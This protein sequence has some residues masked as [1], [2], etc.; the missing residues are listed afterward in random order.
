MALKVDLLQDTLPTGA[1][2]DDIS[3]DLGGSTPNAVM[4]VGGRSTV[5]GTAASDAS[6][7]VG[8]A[9][10]TD[11][12][13]N[14]NVATEDD[15]ASTDVR[16]AIRSDRVREIMNA[17]G[18]TSDGNCDLS[19]F[20]ADDVN[21]T[22][23]NTYGSAWLAQYLAFANGNAEAG[24]G[25]VHATQ[26]QATTVTLGWRPGLVII[27]Y[28]NRELASAGQHC[29]LSVGAL[30]D[31]SD[32][33]ACSVMT[34][35][36]AQ[37][38]GEPYSYVSDAYCGVSINE[39]DGAV[40]HA[41][42]GAITAT[43]FTIETKLGTPNDNDYVFGYLALDLDGDL[44]YVGVQDSPTSTGDWTP[45][46][47]SNDG[48]DIDG[49][50]AML[51]QSF[52][53]TVNTA[54]SGGNAG[55][56]GISNAVSASKEFTTVLHHEDAADPTNT[57]TYQRNQFV[58]LLNPAGT[59]DVE[60]TFTEFG[61]GDLTVDMTNING[62]ARKWVLIVVGTAAAGGAPTLTSAE[63]VR[64]PAG[65]DVELVG[66]NFTG[67]TAVTFNGVNAASFVV[68]SDT[69]ITATTP[70]GLTTGDIV[71]T[72]GSNATLTDGF[73]YWPYELLFAGKNLGYDRA[74]YDSESGT[75]TML[76]PGVGC[77]RHGMTGDPTT[78]FYVQ[79]DLAG[80]YT[81][82]RLIA[83][84]DPNQKLVM[85]DGDVFDFLVG[86][87]DTTDILRVQL[88]YS[89]ANGLRVRV[90][91]YTD[92]GAWSDSI[93]VNIEPCENMFEV[94]WKQSTGSNDGTMD[95]WVNNYEDS[96][97]AADASLSRGR[98]MTPERLMVF[99]LAQSTPTQA[100]AAALSSVT[101]WWGQTRITSSVIQYH[102]PGI[103]AF[104]AGS[105]HDTME[106]YGDLNY[107]VMDGTTI[108]LLN[109]WQATGT[110]A[111]GPR[112]IFANTGG[113]LF[114]LSGSM[115]NNT[116]EGNDLYWY[117]HVDSGPVATKDGGLRGRGNNVVFIGGTYTIG[118]DTTSD[119]RDAIDYA[120]APSD[121]ND[122]L[123]MIHNCLFLHVSA[124]YGRDETFTYWNNASDVS[125]AKN[126]SWER[127]A[128][129]MGLDTTEVG[130][131]LMI[132]GNGNDAEF[133]IRNLS[134]IGNF[135]GRARN[136]NARVGGADR[137]EFVGHVVAG[138]EQKG[139]EWNNSAG[140]DGPNMD[141]V[142]INLHAVGQYHNVNDYFGFLLEPDVDSAT[143]GDYPPFWVWVTE[144]V[145]GWD[146]SGQGGGD[147]WGFIGKGL[148][149]G[150]DAMAAAFQTAWRASGAAFIPHSIAD[151]SKNLQQETDRAVLT[152]GNPHRT[153]LEEGFTSDYVNQVQGDAANT[154]GFHGEAAVD[155]V[156]PLP[157]TKGMYKAWAASWGDP[158]P[159]DPALA[160][161]DRRMWHE[162][163]S[164][165][166]L[167]DTLH[168][169]NT[170]E[171]DPT[172]LLDHS[173]LV[174]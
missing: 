29:H 18:A 91:S 31:D 105:R 124:F 123:N 163:Y 62:T 44:A 135:T 73:K 34:E 63:P 28:G 70:A 15:S 48:T 71:V 147:E 164:D 118:D 77:L 40:D 41:L 80:S 67:A 120:N 43:G 89:T 169:Q 174:M 134:L 99:A 138:Q 154:A 33:Q 156:D 57:S 113:Q 27:V 13:Y 35:D 114:D 112:V 36:D 172:Y 6:V 4:M 58:S 142:Y 107:Y 102:A 119:D 125:V 59:L 109:A 141:T 74:E 26:D 104:G 146:I 22:V 17:S 137:V 108:T 152:A 50:W 14:S 144:E 84:F 8:M 7:A 65:T 60:G 92:G 131:G 11:E 5:N 165:Y 132:A 69:S 66:T 93:W 23:N 101:S 47:I 115:H 87:D 53:T 76:S 155:S 171:A 21:F 157:L 116:D 12:Q 32:K 126:M 39:T 173:Y 110:V 1:G 136:R 61:S 153:A 46:G 117:M 103:Y 16:F 25:A 86:R 133:I 88:G 64:G 72:Q 162:V 168:P 75:I 166:R 139:A 42:L 94:A 85:A 140:A 83:F 145:Q 129:G 98:T 106:L 52:V 81:E 51:V 30:V 96:S 151:Y 37:T 150:D 55:V 79:R 90:G 130:R 111:S 121:V 56:F 127:C 159:T 170:R 143:V 100:R 167:L 160:V 49:I 20:A 54:T 45:T 24:E 78:D 97:K 161:D 2:P 82:V 95:L 148:G 10:A 68:N 158:E 38:A 149:S 122:T 9:T 128:V 3:P 19:S